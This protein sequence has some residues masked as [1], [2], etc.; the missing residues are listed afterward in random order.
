MPRGIHE[1]GWDARKGDIKGRESP[2]NGGWAFSNNKK[3]NSVLFGVEL[4]QS[5][6]IYIYIYK[7]LILGPI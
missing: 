7:K 3:V 5:V 1:E 4:E 6:Y 2:R